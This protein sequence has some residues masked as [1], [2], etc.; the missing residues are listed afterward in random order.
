MSANPIPE[1]LQSDHLFLLVGTNPLPNFVAALLLAKPNAIIWLLH[2][3]GAN[4]EPSTKAAAEQ[5][6]MV[7]RK[8]RTDLTM[9]LEPIPSS[10][11]LQIERRV[12]EILAVVKGLKGMVGL[13][14]T[15]GTKPM[16][17][18][19][20]RKIERVLE[21][22]TTSPVFSYIDPRRVALCVDGRDQTTPQVSFNILK[23]SALRE[24][25]EISMNELA[26]LHGY[27]PVKE[28]KEPE[29]ALPERTPGLLELCAVIAQVHTNPVAFKQWRLWM[30]QEEF[31]TLPN[32]TKYPALKFVNEALD[33]LCGGPG[34]ATPD[35]VAAQLRPHIQTP[36]LVS[37]SKWFLGVWLEEHG[38]A[39]LQQA[40][41]RFPIKFAGKNIEYRAEKEQSDKFE[42]DAAAILGY[43]LFAI[44]CMATET[45][46]K[47][48]EHF[49][50]IFVRARQL[51][52]DEARSGLVCCLDNPGRLQ[53]EIERSWDAKGKL[54]VFGRNDLKDLTRA[55]A[56][57][58]QTANG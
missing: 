11:N 17:F 44:S 8:K 13:N 46:K 14:Y 53:T 33:N 30:E 22:T 54:K 58:F 6:E 28:T 52:G 21:K 18:H 48:K 15:G 23:D 12:G 37:C 3:D 34:M 29:W 4:G 5:L 40:A 26:A 20:Y 27:E 50:E 57:W 31:Q 24:M 16:S 43:Q 39:C 7:L 41:N 38:P 1:T 45:K 47:A 9:K 25:V 10:N 2:S 42:L 55:F 56:D 32:E 19:T 49:I 35:Q 51:G 36:S